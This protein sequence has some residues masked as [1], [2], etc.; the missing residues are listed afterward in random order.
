MFN[1]NSLDC[2]EGTG[3]VTPADGL[4]GKVP[5]GGRLPSST[6]ERKFL[7]TLDKDDDG[8]DKKDKKSAK[9]SSDKEEKDEKDEGE[10]D[11]KDNE[12]DEKEK[13]DELDED[14]DDKDKEDL[15]EDDDD[16][17]GLEL[18][19]TDDETSVYFQLKK[20]DK[21]IFKKVPEL[22]ATIFREQEFTKRFSTIDEAEE[23]KD[24]AET[25][26][27]F[28][29]DIEAG[30]AKTFL[31]AVNALDS[32]E[33]KGILK[34]FAGNFIPALIEV[35]KEL[36][37]DIIAPEFKKMLRAALKSKDENIVQSAKNLNYFLWDST[38]VEKDEGFTSTKSGKKDPR[39]DRVAKKEQEIEE[40]QLKSF[41]NDVR[42][43]CYNRSK[44]I[45][46]KSL[47]GFD[48]SDL[49][50]KH[51]TDEIFTRTISA[52]DKDRRYSG[53]MHALWKKSK[54]DGYTTSGKE[55]LINTFLSRAKGIIPKVRQQVLA[56]AKLTAKKATEDGDKKQPVRIPSNASS[57]RSGQPTGKIDIKRI[58]WTKTTEKDLLD[59]KAPVYKK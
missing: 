55:S 34:E 18:E 25:F 27:K 14:D 28:Q 38:D 56:E 58:D 22:R 57:G 33:D 24:L 30:D 48:I 39:E 43:V 35:N 40:R 9:S 41:S 29:N 53:N 49:T 23:A 31:S 26:V 4:G 11:E 5:E 16:E 47:D 6:D 45:I 17:D 21:D 15:E 13:E 51:L 46:G 12:G 8:S 59:G 36:Y 44:R 1:F 52:L 20:T 7:N 32:E 2:V 19:G 10:L 42:E 50:K 54:S 3:T 37:Y